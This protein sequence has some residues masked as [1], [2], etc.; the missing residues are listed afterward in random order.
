MN[1]AMCLLTASH[2]FCLANGHQVEDLTFGHML[3]GSMMLRMVVPRKVAGMVQ[4]LRR[5]EQDK[6]QPQQVSILAGSLYYFGLADS[7]YLQV[8]HVHMHNAA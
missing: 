5:L 2:A 1:Q 8:P 4:Q 3:M 6:K 7:A